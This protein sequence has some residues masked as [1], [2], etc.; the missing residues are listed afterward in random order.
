M[1]VATLLHSLVSS[2]TPT[3]AQPYSL[4]LPFSRQEISE[5]LELSPETV[6]RTLSTLRREQVLDARGRRLTI[7]D[8]GK[9]RAAARR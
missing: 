1:K 8:L 3:P 9:L 5:I 4:L 7:H 2:E 6:S